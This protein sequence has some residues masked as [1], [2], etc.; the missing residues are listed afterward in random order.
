MSTKPFDQMLCNLPT[1][2]WRCILPTP[3]LKMGK[4]RLRPAVE[5]GVGFYL[6]CLS[7]SPQ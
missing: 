2:S 6:P 1:L 4:L 7:L 5:G 3:T